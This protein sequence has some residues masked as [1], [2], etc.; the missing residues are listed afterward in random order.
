[1]ELANLNGAKFGDRPREKLIGIAF[2]DPGRCCTLVRTVL[3]TVKT[4]V[5]SGTSSLTF[6]DAGRLSNVGGSA[7][8]SGD[9]VL[10]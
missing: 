4:R 10:R 5:P 3:S 1:V 6:T 9:Y 7:E 2:A 8:K